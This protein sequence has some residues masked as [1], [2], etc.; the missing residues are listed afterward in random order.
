M[1]TTIGTL[2][3]SLRAQLDAKRADVVASAPPRTMARA[4]SL[5][6]LMVAASTGGPFGEPSKTPEKGWLAAPSR[7]VPVARP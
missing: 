2:A 3:D 7:S 5:P 6:R 4:G 1:P